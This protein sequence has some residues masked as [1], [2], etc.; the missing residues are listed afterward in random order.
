MACLNAVR[1]DTRTTGEWLCVVDRTGSGSE[2]R[3]TMTVRVE[4]VHGLGDLAALAADLGERLRVDL[5]VR[6][7]V[8]VVPP[9]R[10]SEVTNVGREGK[11]RR[12]LDR[13]PGYER[14]Y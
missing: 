13:R 7:D 1:A 14:H 2:A 8:E 3:D 12:L 6:V 11:A 5:G 10:L 4:H 9:G